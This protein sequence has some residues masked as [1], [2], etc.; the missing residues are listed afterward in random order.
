MY[1]RYEVRSSLSEYPHSGFIGMMDIMD[2]NYFELF[3]DILFSL[4]GR[5]DQYPE[6]PAPPVFGK[7][8]ADLAV[9]FFTEEG[10]TV[11]Q[12]VIQ[13]A[14]HIY[15]Q[16]R[17]EDGVDVTP[18]TIRMDE[19]QAKKFTV[20]YSDTYQYV[21]EMTDADLDMVISSQ[22]QKGECEGSTTSE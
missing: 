16:A 8:N 15:D 6:L 20:L 5:I 13:Q 10:N 19:E 18:I 11:F 17:E 9:C 21:F 3:E 7:E 2:D 12:E 1:Y 14:L 22:A 4:G